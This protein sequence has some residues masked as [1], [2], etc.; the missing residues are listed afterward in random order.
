M[1]EQSFMS[2]PLVQR[3]QAKL[4]R[5]ARATA[6]VY[7]DFVWT[8]WSKAIA[9]RIPS[10]KAWLEELQAENSSKDL[11]I[12]QR[13][14]SDL[15]EFVT[16]YVSPTTGKPYRF[17]S[18]KIFVTAVKSFLHFHLGKTSLEPYTFDLQSSEERLQAE[19]EKEDTKP[20]SVEEYRK[21]VY[22]AKT[23]RDKTILLTLA[24][25]MGVAEWLQFAHEWWKYAKAIQER[26]VPVVVGVIRPKTGRHYKVWL[27]DDSVEHLSLLLDMREKELGRPLTQNDQLFVT[28]EGGKITSHR[29]QR[30][31]RNLASDLGLEPRERGKILYRIRP[32]ELEGISSE[33][34][35][36]TP[37]YA[38]LWLSIASDIR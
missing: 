1:A 31:I 4:L 25:G 10:L 19:K 9:P 14:A 3:W 36:R 37:A 12:R 2:D 27:W 16:S 8:Y 35:A 30:M 23:V 38:L 7:C 26:K 34:F 32:H 24:S 18:R 21:L 15:E 28:H 29:I 11:Q 17:K 5:K 22:G 13:W 6:N 33:R 20:I